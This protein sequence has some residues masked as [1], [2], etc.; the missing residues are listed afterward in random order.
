MSV[1][2]PNIIYILGDDHRVEQQ[3]G[4]GHPILQTPNLD[5]LARDGVQFTHAFCT[6]P[7]CTPSR[8]SHY[9][10][11]WERRHGIN[12]NSGS[13]LDPVAW[14]Q[15]FPMQLK[16]EG[17]FLGWV[18]KN[19]V[20]VGGGQRGYD[21]G[22]FESVFDYWY[23]N[24]GHS[25]FYP[26][27]LAERGGEIYHN[28]RC[29]TQVEVFEEGVLNFLDP[30]QAFIE[31]CAPPL[32]RRP[33]GQP[34]CLVVALVEPH[35]PWVMG[36]PSQYP[37]AKL[38]LPPNIADTPR[39]R[40]DFG[41]YLA[42]ITYMDGQVG[43]VLDTLEATGGADDTVVLFTS[44][45]G[46]QFPG[47][48]WTNWNTGIHTALVARWPGRITADK[49]TDALVQ[50]ADILPTLVEL[51][52]GKPGAYPYDG[53]SFRD[54]L[55]GKKQTHRQFVYGVHNNIP[56]GPPYPIRSVNDGEYHYIRN[57]LPDE[58]YIEKHLM[59]VRGNGALNNPYWGTWMWDSW[60][61][62]RSYRLVKRFMHR[63][64]EQLYR[65]ADDPYEMNNLAGDKTQ[66]KRLAKLRVELDRWMKAQNDPGAAVDTP[67]AIQ[68]SKRG[69]YLHGISANRSL[70]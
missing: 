53:S 25:G 57:L 5:A 64:A 55:F 19:H 61:T 43:Q 34:F 9:T 40:Q 8:T 29:D 6:S 10:G 18:G 58:I 49:R 70:R 56:E 7:A 28:A 31:N 37:P 30:Q 1:E 46:S 21:S 15:S 51:A 33:E 2:G 22:Y 44:E 36:D 65:V 63:P 13:S 35:V 54:A 11:Q 69:E 16:N 3:G 41:K 39:T 52:G 20:P 17:Y 48:K 38:K 4:K 45:Q 68:A 47:N 24:H 50:Y 59:G 66:A 12:F 23:G 32:P 60:N 67:E 27:E 14:E 42:E 26:K 62:P